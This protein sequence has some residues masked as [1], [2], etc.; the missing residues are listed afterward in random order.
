MFYYDF[1]S[2][3]GF[4]VGYTFQKLLNKLKH[5]IDIYVFDVIYI[6]T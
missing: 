3:S 1:L 5:R 6:F 2:Y 4:L